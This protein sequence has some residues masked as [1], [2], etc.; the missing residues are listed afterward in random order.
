MTLALTFGIVAP[1]ASSDVLARLAELA[2][3]FRERDLL[4]LGPRTFATYKELAGSVREGTTDVAWLAPV[5]YAWLAEG[6]TPIGSIRRES[7]SGYS[8]ALVV[9]EASA[10]KSLDDL[11]TAKGLRAGWVDPWSA[12]GYVVPRIELARA[13]I[14]AMNVFAKETFH[15]SH[16]RALEA[17]A[18][19]EA[20]VV[21]TYSRASVDGLVTRTL[22]T[23]GPIPNDVIAVRRNL[24][25]QE[26]EAAR[27][28]LRAAC[29]DDTGRARMRALLGGDQLDDGVG[30]GHVKLRLAYESAIASGLFD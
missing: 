2:A 23:W 25:P 13:G 22:A 14:L 10:V 26:Y 21:A 19:D 27:D 20:D 9:K 3:F 29:A 8:A 12:A 15:G 17:L 11:R 7:G 6:V 24:G 18:K 4:D 16:T 5:S 30:D 28:A 1:E